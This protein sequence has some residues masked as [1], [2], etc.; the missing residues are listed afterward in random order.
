MS[1]I[2]TAVISKVILSTDSLTS[3][4]L[5]IKLAPGWGAVL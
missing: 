3:A 5:I 2:V 4:V 1:K